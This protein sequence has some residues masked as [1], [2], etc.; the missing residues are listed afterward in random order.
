MACGPR[1]TAFPAVSRPKNDSPSG[2]AQSEEELSLPVREAA[3]EVLR[4]NTPIN[5][6]EMGWAGECRRQ[7][8]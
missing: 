2:Q 7:A 4:M 8:R 6:E 5:I 1:W 3:M